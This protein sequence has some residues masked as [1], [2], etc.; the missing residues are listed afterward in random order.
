MTRPDE[1]AALSSRLDTAVDRLDALDHRY[2]S[3]IGRNF[4]GGPVGIETLAASLS[5][6]RDALED[7]IEP[8]LIQQGFIQRTPRGRMLTLHAFA[9]LGLEAPKTATN[10]QAPLF[11][12]GDNE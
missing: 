5:E 7:V 9:H 10:G 11:A 3:I 8:F 4:S 1:I 2:L 12:D 6:T